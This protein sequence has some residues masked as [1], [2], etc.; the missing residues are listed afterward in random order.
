MVN[1]INLNQSALVALKNLNQ[2]TEDLEQT[3]NRVSTG[4]EVG[5]A[6]D[7]AAIYSVAQGLRSDTAS[8]SVVK[9]SLD[10]AQSIGD[11]ALAAAET[12]SDLFIEMRE[13]AL[14]GQD[15]SLEPNQRQAA[16]TDFAALIAQV[17]SIVDDAE[18]DGA[19]ILNGSHPTGIEFIA[20][21][22]GSDVLTLTAQDFNLGGT[23]IT[24]TATHD[25]STITG[26]TTALSAVQTSLNNINAALAEIGASTKQIENHSAFVTRL[27]DTLTAG[28]GELVDADLGKESALLQ[29]LQVKQQ[30]TVQSVSIANS[31][32]QTILS[33]FQN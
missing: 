31:A 11:V 9:T 13:K 30:L 7:N 17:T 23:I 25:V 19:N 2:T 24:V 16:Q 5:S 27:S 6:K 3:N 1:S 15:P 4:L 26:A 10:R 33:L 8:L 29:A 12:I 28:V 21:A 20:D 22:D 14:L 18:F 32:P